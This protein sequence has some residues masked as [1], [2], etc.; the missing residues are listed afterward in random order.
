MKR[1]DH[2][3]ALVEEFKTANPDIL[4]EPLVIER[5]WH[6]GWTAKETRRFNK[7]SGWRNAS[8]I[9]LF[10]DFCTTDNWIDEPLDDSERYSVI[11][12]IGKTD[13]NKYA[14]GYR[15]TDYNHKVNAPPGP[16][17]A[18]RRGRPD[19]AWFPYRQID[20]IRVGEPYELEQHLIRNV[21]PFFNTNGTV[22]WNPHFGV[23]ICLIYDEDS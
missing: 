6:H 11:R 14:F 4:T 8:G 9:Y 13:P 19:E 1:H 12:Y 20:I 18:C 2:I 10:V 3:L 17:M 23:G 21:H 22:P 5:V 15:M 16:Q 7:Q